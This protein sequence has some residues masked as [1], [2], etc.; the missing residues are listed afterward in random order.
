MTK[1]KIG[2]FTTLIAWSLF[3][4]VLYATGDRSIQN[5][6]KCPPENGTR[7]GIQSKEGPVL[8]P[9]PGASGVLMI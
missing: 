3:A 5:P 8:V 6:C 7:E 1:L 9:S 4:F 2:A